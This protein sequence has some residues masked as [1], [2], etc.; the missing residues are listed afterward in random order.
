M[1]FNSCIYYFCFNAFFEH[2]Y[3]S[4]YLFS[5]SIRLA[6]FF[7]FFLLIMV[8]MFFFY[9]RIKNSFQI[10]SIILRVAFCC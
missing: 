9:A 7:F 3:V 5:L 6:F 8:F 10:K 1:M 2:V 4:E